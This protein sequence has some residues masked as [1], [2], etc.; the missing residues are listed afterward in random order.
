MMAMKKK[1]KIIPYAKF[2]K[3]NKVIKPT[4]CN[5]I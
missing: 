2:E 5:H 4:I 3:K 1:Y